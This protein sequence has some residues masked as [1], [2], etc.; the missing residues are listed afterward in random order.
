[1][2]IRRKI[3]NVF[4]PIIGEILCLH[5]VLPERSAFKSNRDLEITPDYLERLILEKQ[6]EGALFVDLDTFVASANGKLREKH[7]V[8]VT[9][10]DGFADVYTHAY[11]V[12]KQYGVPFTLYVSTDLPDGKADIWW[13][14]LEQLAK[15]DEEWF[16]KTV[17]QIYDRHEPIA[18]AMHALTSSDVDLI[19]CRQQSLSW[20]QIRT[21]VLEGLCTVGSHG[22]SHSAMSLLSEEQVK[23]EL[24]ESKRRLEEILG[25]EVRHFSYPHSFF[26]AM[27]NRW[28]WEAG[29]QTAV[30]GY[31]GNTRR[32]NN[33]RFFYREFIV[34][35]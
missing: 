2:W 27:T 17:E 31:G 16:E 6:N 5:R 15:G 3:Y 11:P 19:L 9:F 12:L 8:H 32:E 26:N 29:Y 24:S 7:L 18:A 30:V 21:M 35:P 13:L 22:V 23:T 33:K 25:V 28:V 34:Q 20:E 1:M 4:H 14:Q 10:D